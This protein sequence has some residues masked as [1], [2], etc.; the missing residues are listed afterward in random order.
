MSAAKEETR[1]FALDVL[2]TIRRK[3][4]MLSVCS[5]VYW[6]ELLNFHSLGVFVGKGRE[7]LQVALGLGLTEQI[8]AP[9][10]LL[11]DVPFHH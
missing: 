6:V 7:A 10:G 9:R 8:Q 11:F 5:V 2:L 1:V 4:S 3:N